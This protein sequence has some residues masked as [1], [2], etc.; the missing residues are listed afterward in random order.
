MLPDSISNVV[1]AS[2]S[3][4][5]S[6]LFGRSI[7]GRKKSG[8]LVTAVLLLALSG[9]S[10]TGDFLAQEERSADELYNSALNE[11]AVGD[12]TKASPLF[13][14]VERQHPYS[15][16]ATQAQL[17][18]AWSLYQ[19]NSYGATVNALERFVELNPAHPDV[20]YALY[21][22]AQS[23]YEQIVDVERDAGMT[24]L[25]KEAFEA[26][27]TRFPESKYARDARLKLELTVSHLAGK[28]MSVGRFYLERGHYDAALRRFATVVKDYDRS[29]QTP[30]ALYRM[31]E[32]YLALGLDGEADR[33]AAVLNYNYPESVW[34]E[35]MLALIDAPTTN[36][37]P[38]LFETL[39]DKATSIF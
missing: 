4:F 18:S 2:N 28:E 14:E 37:D 31:V 19:S 26:L 9:C 16:L 13:D 5:N 25:A 35:R 33:S 15:S 8:Y 23:Y 7:A 12:I 32:A 3:G 17:M 38:G 10:G 21:L 6:S 36:H 20:D 11:V 24:V 27:L 30:E 29:N 34:T 1:T 39:V 22:K